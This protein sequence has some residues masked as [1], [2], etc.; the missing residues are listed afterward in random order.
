[1]HLN[2]GDEVTFSVEGSRLV[3]TPVRRR[4]YTLSELLDGMSE[5]NLHSEIDWGE[6]MGREVW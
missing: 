5:E 4:K 3:V 6:P 2:E 1:M